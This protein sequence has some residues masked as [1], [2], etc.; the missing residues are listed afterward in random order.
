MP[1]SLLAARSV[2]LII[3]PSPTGRDEGVGTRKRHQRLDQITQPLWSVVPGTL[4]P[5][6]SRICCSTIDELSK[7]VRQE[8]DQYLV[9]GWAVLF[10]C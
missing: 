4:S 1:R 6:D 2:A 5:H 3:D 10:N 8:C 7:N 9:L